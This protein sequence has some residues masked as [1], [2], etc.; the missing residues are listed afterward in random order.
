[1]CQDE[2]EARKAQDTRCSCP[3]GIE[4]FDFYPGAKL[5]QHPDFR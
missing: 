5:V 4:D 1:M 3:S 2:I